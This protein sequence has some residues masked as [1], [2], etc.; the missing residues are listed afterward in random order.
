MSTNT[1]IILRFLKYLAWVFGVAGFWFG[2]SF[3]IGIY[4]SPDFGAFYFAGVFV[5]TC[6]FEC[7]Y[8]N[9]KA[10]VVR[11]S[12]TDTDKKL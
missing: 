1:K 8:R 4:Y 12:K 10:S 9:A 7:C 11:E 2:G 3:A 5:L 6:V